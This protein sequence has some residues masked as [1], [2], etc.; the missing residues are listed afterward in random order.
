MK[1][2]EIDFSTSKRIID[3]GIIHEKYGRN[4]LVFLCANGDICSIN[5]LSGDDVIKASVLFFA[6]VFLN[7]QRLGDFI[8]YGF[9]EFPASYATEYSNQILEFNQ[10]DNQKENSTNLII[11]RVLMK[12]FPY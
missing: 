5:P 2:K 10:F 1:K 3:S 7:I 8:T 12:G 11:K 6:D 4:I 9:G